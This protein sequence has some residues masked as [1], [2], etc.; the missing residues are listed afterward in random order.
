MS[1]SVCLRPGQDMSVSTDLRDGGGSSS[2]QYREGFPVGQRGD[3]PDFVGGKPDGSK[4]ILY[5]DTKKR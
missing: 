1:V 3:F 2:D 5:I 4:K